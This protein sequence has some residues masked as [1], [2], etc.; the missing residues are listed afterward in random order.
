MVSSP[1]ATEYGNI[2]THLRGINENGCAY[3]GGMF[4]GSKWQNRYLQAGRAGG[5]ALKQFCSARRAVCCWRLEAMN[6]L[7]GEF[8][9]DA[10]AAATDPGGVPGPTPAIPPM[11]LCTLCVCL[12]GYC[13]VP[14]LNVEIAV[15]A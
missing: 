11:L 5:G 8:H 9:V 13:K 10:T 1:V 12:G 4:A 2:G 14:G 7:Q 3:A 6:I 15:S